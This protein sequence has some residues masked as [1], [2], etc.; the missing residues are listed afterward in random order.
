MDKDLFYT[1]TTKYLSGE[2]TLQETDQLNEYL[3]NEYFLDLFLKINE[4]W[5]QKGKTNNE[6]IFD[7]NRGLTLLR[8]GLA[9]QNENKPI[10]I[11]RSFKKYY[12]AAAGLAGIAL[13]IVFIFYASKNDLVSVTAKAGIIKQFDLPDGSHITLNA[14]STLQF[15]QK[16]NSATREVYLSGEALFKVR[17]DKTHPFI[18]H[19][20]S[21]ATKAVG[22]VFNIK[23]FINE[24]HINIS[25][26]KGKVLISNKPNTLHDQVLL[27]MQMLTVYKKTGETSINNF[28]PELI[29]S[30]KDQE[31]H[32]REEPLPEVFNSIARKYGVTINYDERVF[33]KCR[34]NA[35]FTT[36]SVTEV[37][38]VLKFALRFNYKI[39]TDQKGGQLIV[40]NGSGC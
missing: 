5:V 40:I 8:G 24:D 35:N 1:L 19:T 23:A 11:I 29:T 30:W 16:F 7:L 13:S 20:D 3:E 12:A 39:G 36:E 31:L 38:E 27:P 17:S 25:L 33:K 6:H 22:T 10:R 26:I 32:F 21:Y 37:L 9:K 18:V 2:C 15:P 4:T 28:S 14:G 34:V